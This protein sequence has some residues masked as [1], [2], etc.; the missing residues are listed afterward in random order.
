[1]HVICCHKLSPKTAFY[2]QG[3][4]LG[5]EL[6]IDRYIPPHGLTIQLPANSSRCMVSQRSRLPTIDKAKTYIFPECAPH[7]ERR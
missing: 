3:G 6:L 7:L 5:L 4:M 2:R 1:M